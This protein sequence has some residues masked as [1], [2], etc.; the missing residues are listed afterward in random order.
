MSDTDSIADKLTR[1]ELRRG[2]PETIWGGKGTGQSCSGC[3]GP[4]ARDDF[5][6][7]IDYPGAQGVMRFHQACLFIWDDYRKDYPASVG[8]A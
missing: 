6:Y 1:G 8:M 2:T 7:E 3:D 5:E 4:I